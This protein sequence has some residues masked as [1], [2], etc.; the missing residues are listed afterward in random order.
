MSGREKSYI[1]AL[2]K[3]SVCIVFLLTELC[4]MVELLNKDKEQSMAD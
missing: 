2:I 4:N 3:S 1:R